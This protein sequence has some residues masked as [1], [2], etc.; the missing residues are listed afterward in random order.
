MAVKL[1]N[2]WL[3]FFGSGWWKPLEWRAGSIYAARVARWNG[4]KLSDFKYCCWQEHL[5]SQAAIF[6]Q[7][8]MVAFKL[9]L[10]DH[11]ISLEQRNQLWPTLQWQCLSIIPTKS[12]KTLIS[13]VLLNSK[14]CSSS[15]DLYFQFSQRSLLARMPTS[16][17]TFTGSLLIQVLSPYNTVAAS[18]H[19]SNGWSSTYT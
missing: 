16:N 7:R 19:K 12:G 6:W 11:K 15:N 8:S 4:I 2:I 18:Y 17:S 14:T 9:P 13:H 1:D 10:A 5:A 3:N